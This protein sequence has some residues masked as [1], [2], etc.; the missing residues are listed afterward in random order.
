MP[1]FRTSLDKRVLV[2]SPDYG[3]RLQLH[4]VAMLDAA[5][6]VVLNKADS[7]GARAARSEIRQRLALN[8]RSQKLVA[9]VANRHRDPGVDQLFGLLKTRSS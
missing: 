1:F 7:A 2:I 3:S 8:A 9:T 5:D 6:I 4:K